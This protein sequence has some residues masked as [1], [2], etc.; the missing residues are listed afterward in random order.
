MRMHAF[1]CQPGAQNFGRHEVPADCTR[2][3]C[4]DLYGQRAF[5]GCRWFRKWKEQV[6]TARAREHE[7]YVVFK[8]GQK[9]RGKKPWPPTVH[10]L[11][12]YK[13][14]IE[15]SKEEKGKTPGPG[16]GW[17]QMG[18]VAWLQKEGIPYKEI[19]IEEFRQ[20]L[21]GGDFDGPRESGSSLFACCA[22]APEDALEVRFP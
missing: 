13:E 16:L 17:S 11:P 10:L 19:D 7:I 15:L 1:S 8:E 4:H 2:C 5:F 18:E 6:R 12:E 3:S 21:S 9:G 14:Y 20:M 22:A